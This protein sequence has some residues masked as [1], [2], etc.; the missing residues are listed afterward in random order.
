MKKSA[1]PA[2]ESGPAAGET[3]PAVEATTAETEAAAST[4]AVESTEAANASVDPDPAEQV[5][6]E[7]PAEVTAKESFT[8]DELDA[9]LAIESSKVKVAEDAL[10]ANLEE[11]ET[12]KTAASTSEKTAVE[13]KQNALYWELA[14]ESKS[15]LALEDLEPLKELPEAAFRAS[16]ALGLKAAEKAAKAPTTSYK[17]LFDG[18]DYTK[19]EKRDPLGFLDKR[20]K[21]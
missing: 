15:V 5:E 7:K 10:A 18:K 19:P 9:A 4:E 11:L 17:E 8:R 16:V 20:Y 6:L 12:L 3:G 13:A 14:Y 1:A 2:G 21:K